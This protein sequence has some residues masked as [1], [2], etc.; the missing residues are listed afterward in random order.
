MGSAGAAPDAVPADAR[1]EKR[2]AHRSLCAKASYGTQRAKLYLGS[3]LRVMP[4]AMFQSERRRNRR[5]N[6]HQRS[7]LAVIKVEG[8]TGIHEVRAIGVNAS[9]GGALVFGDSEIAAG[10][11]VELLMTLDIGGF[12]LV[13]LRC[14]GEVVRVESRTA[15]GKFPIAIRCIRRFRVGALNLGSE[16]LASVH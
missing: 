9:K 5:F 3:Q 7:P 6:V 13:H 11:R 1:G 14:A 2:A 12:P 4:P 10:T 8:A 16:A 15:A